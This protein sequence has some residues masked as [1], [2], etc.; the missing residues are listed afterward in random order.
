MPSA[1]K[2]PAGKS[3]AQSPSAPAVSVVIP[4]VDRIDLLE[5]CLRGLA[6]QQD[7]D[8]EVLVVHDGNCDIIRLLDRWVDEL[9]LRALEVEV[10]GA[11]AK[12]N[13]G[14]RAARAPIIAFTDDDC[15]PA[16]GWLREV[17]SQL[18]DEAIALVQ[19]KVLAHP[20]D[21]QVGGL[22]ARTIEV[23]GALETFPNANLVYR[24]AS[25]EAVNGYDE[26]LS[27][28]EDTDLAWR[29]LALGGEAKFLD[30][31]LVWHA[32]RPVDF[33]G[34]L[35]S[36]PRWAALPEVVRR[37][38][39]LRALTYRRYF[40]KDTHPKAWLS[41][42]GLVIAPHHPVALLLALPHL[43]ARR[44]PSLIVSDWAECL[45]MAV[46]SLRWRAILL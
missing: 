27:S 31:A 26:R 25:L 42:L 38:P 40:W 28:G 30:S 22:F 5:R 37:H 16:P 21:V 39:Q 6:A 32:V 20:D 33:A 1:M 7:V 13:A 4:T 11:A 34:H 14:W 35:R 9:A 45:V 2:A 23:T 12:R 15:E 17:A 10:R 24:R 19:G 44:H 46:G 18:D 3:S 29:I 36:L 43:R 41:L 8:F